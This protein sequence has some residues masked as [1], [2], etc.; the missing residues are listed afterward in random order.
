MNCLGQTQ[1]VSD[2]IN[3]KGSVSCPNLFK[4]HIWTQSQRG[5][6]I[7]RK[8]QDKSNNEEIIPSKEAI[9]LGKKLMEIGGRGLVIDG[10]DNDIE[11]IIERGRP[12]EIKGRKMMMGEPSQCHSNTAGL[13]DSNKDKVNIVTGYALAEDGDWRQ[14]SWGVMKEKG[15][16]VETTNKYLAYFGFILTDDESEEFVYDN[17]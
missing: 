4:E 12:F 8:K 16:I 14:H 15:K 11:K 1:N 7:F 3:Q 5:M 13:Y 10:S 9:E 6:F 17:Y 2:L